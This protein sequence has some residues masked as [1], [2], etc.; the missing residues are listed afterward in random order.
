MICCYLIWSGICKTADEALAFYGRQRTKNSKGVTIPSQK[1]YVYYL[2]R[3]LAEHRKRDSGDWKGGSGTDSNDTHAHLLTTS[4]SVSASASA[5]ASSSMTNGS[6]NIDNIADRYES[7]GNGNGTILAHAVDVKMEQA[8]GDLHKRKELSYR[9]DVKEESFESTCKSETTKSTRNSSDSYTIT[10]DESID[11]QADER[12]ALRRKSDCAILNAI[13][14]GV[15]LSA[16]FRPP[17]PGQELTVKRI[18]MRPAPKKGIYGPT[19]TIRDS[20]FNV[21]YDY[22][23][24]SSCHEF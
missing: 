13:Q 15:D 8:N 12:W 10:T 1:R 4:V 14:D 18:I 20:K 11:V 17:Y 9:R 3:V 19:F 24:S 23:V 16:I 5:S 2:E 21:I 22:K 6:S 7:N